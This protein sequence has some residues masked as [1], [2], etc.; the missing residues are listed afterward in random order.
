MKNH[1]DPDVTPDNKGESWS[2]RTDNWPSECIDSDPNH[3]LGAWYAD[4]DGGD[5]P[6]KANECSWDDEGAAL[7][8]GGEWNL[9]GRG[10]IPQGGQ[11]TAEDDEEVGVSESDGQIPEGVEGPHESVEKNFEDVEGTHE[12][13]DRS[14][15]G[16]EAARA[17]RQQS[18]NMLRTLKTRK[19]R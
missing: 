18:I 13:V 11:S 1:A 2:A 5:W 15:E 4:G 10:M 19:R 12:G 14:S 17:V 7:V 3:E 9:D 6:N 16:G 8:G